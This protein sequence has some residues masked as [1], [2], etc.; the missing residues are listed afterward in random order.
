MSGLIRRRGSRSGYGPWCQSKEAECAC[1]S[2]CLSVCLSGS[3]LVC[4]SARVS[5]NE[6]SERALLCLRWPCS[7][8][9]Q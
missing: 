3:P 6:E 8:A 2:V 1:L 5:L 9:L 4:L 7:S